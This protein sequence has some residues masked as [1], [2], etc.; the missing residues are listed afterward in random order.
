[1]IKGLD[2]LV[3]EVNYKEMFK[4]YVPTDYALRVVNTIK[5]IHGTTGTE[6]KTPLIHYHMLD[7]IV[8]HRNTLNVAARGTAKS[9]L[10][11][12]VVFDLALFGELPNFGDVDVMMYVSDT[13]ENGVKT[14]FTNLKFTWENSDFL[15]EYIPNARFTQDECELANKDGHRLFVKGFGV[16]TG[17][18]GFTRYSNRP[19][20]AILDDLFTDKNAQSPTVVADIETIIYNA[21]EQALHPS[22]RKFIWTGT[23]FNKKDPLYK[24]TYSKSWNA[25]VY[26][27]CNAFPCTEEDFVSAWEDRFTYESIKFTYDKLL[28]NGKIDGFNQELMLRIISDEDRL[29]S[30]MDIIWYDRKEVLN[31][32]HKYNFYITTDFATSE[33]QKA[34]FSVISTWAYNAKGD[35]LYVDGIVKRQDMSINIE[36]L[37][38]FVSIYKPQSVGIEITGQQKGFVSWLRQEQIRRNIWFV[39]AKDGNT[40]EEG[41]RPNTSKLVRFNTVV[42]LFKSRKIWFPEDLKDSMELKEAMDEI[43]HVT[44]SGFKSVHDDFIDTISMLPLMLPWK[45]VE[46]SFSHNVPEDDVYS[47]YRHI[48]ST[49]SLDSYIV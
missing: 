2:E 41:L 34:D 33:K 25:S 16:S 35:W 47:K 10:S 7:N 30:P 6:N 12:Y 9:T 19:K 1:M 31:N 22:K 45:P 29:I 42:P 38:R 44:S 40:K 20:V 49:Y 11:K 28:D 3:K 18:R 48:E 21:I 39:F 17:V 13:A 5:L 4:N 14:F 8:K 27:V 32:K 43:L 26:P 37:F 24:A 15:K 36:D 46:D 23:P